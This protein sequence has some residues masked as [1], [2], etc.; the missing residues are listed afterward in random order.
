ML[1]WI[2]RHATRQ[3][4]IIWTTMALLSHT[5][6]SVSLAMMLGIFG[7]LRLIS[8]RHIPRLAHLE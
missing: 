1:G 8:D 2:D 5:G 7:V 6:A 3:R 4:Q